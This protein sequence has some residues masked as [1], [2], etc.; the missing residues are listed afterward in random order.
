MD[1]E[2]KYK[3][4]LEVARKYYNDQAMPIGTSFKLEKIFPELAEDK[5]RKELM[6]HLQEGADGYEPAGGAEDYSR[7]L[8]WV[9]KHEPVKSC[10]DGMQTD[11]QKQVANLLASV[12]NREQEYTPGYV[13]WV[14]QSLL[15]YAKN[16]LQKTSEWKQRDEMI[17]SC[18]GM[19]LTDA[20]E[21]RFFDYSVTLQECLNWLESI[22][23]RVIE[24]N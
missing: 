17:R 14:A 5:V 21:G 15:G 16:E 10:A 2:E 18:I 1:Y 12:N 4:A 23:S 19:I 22:K 6:K 7:W 13:T 8:D 11:F 20:P 9:K 24:E 3:V